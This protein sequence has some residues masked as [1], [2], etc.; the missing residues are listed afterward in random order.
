MLL[1][2]KGAL[3]FDAFCQLGRLSVPA[4]PKGICF[5]VLMGIPKNTSDRCWSMDPMG[6]EGL[7]FL[8]GT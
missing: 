4:C 6:R 7:F 2:V 1:D 3:F 5:E 8:F